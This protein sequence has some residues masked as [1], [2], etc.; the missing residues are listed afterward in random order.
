MSQNLLQIINQVH[1]IS[2]KINELGHFETFKRNLDKFHSLFE[3]DGYLIQDPTSE[4]Y[5]ESRNDCEASI[6]GKIHSG[7]RISKTI[8]P[9]VYQKV[10]NELKLIQKG[11]VIVE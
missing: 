8:K 9:I 10:N 2:R 4:K 6:V 3:D 5:T 1:E 7:M 11:I